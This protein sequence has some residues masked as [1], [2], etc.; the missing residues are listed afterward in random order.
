MGTGEH[1][2]IQSALAQALL[3]DVDFE[4]QLLLLGIPPP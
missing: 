3:Q 4:D 2:Q 1:R